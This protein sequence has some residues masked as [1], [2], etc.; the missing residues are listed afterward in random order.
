MYLYLK[1]HPSE[2]VLKC[3]QHWQ[4]ALLVSFTNSFQRDFCDSFQ[5]K[6]GPKGPEWPNLSIFL[7]LQHFSQDWLIRLFLIFYMKL[8]DH[9]Y[10]KL[11]KLKT[12]EILACS[13]ADQEGLKWPN[14]CVCLLQQHYF[15]YWLISFFYILHEVEGT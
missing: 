12:W 7:L 3:S 1:Y 5:S 11:M 6:N 2:E 10:S 14:L 9:K 13:K 8:R 4:K 15:Q